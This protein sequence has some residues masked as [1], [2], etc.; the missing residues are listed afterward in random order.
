MPALWRSG[1]ERLMADEEKGQKG[2]RE[3]GSGEKAQGEKGG[4]KARAQEAAAAEQAAG[5][6]EE[7]GSPAREQQ[8]ALMLD[9]KIT[10]RMRVP[11]LAKIVINMSLSAARENVKILDSA[12]EELQLIVGQKVVTTK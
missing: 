7:A 4:R 12:A 1:G 3:K 10:N 9:L 11:T 2:K 5:A 6:A 8:P